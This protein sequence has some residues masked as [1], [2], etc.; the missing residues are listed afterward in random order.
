[1]EKNFLENN[2]LVLA[3][4]LYGMAFALTYNE[5]KSLQL[6]SDSF[7]IFL[8]EYSETLLKLSYKNIEERI[9]IK[10]F[11]ICFDLS[12]GLVSP[13][14]PEDGIFANFYALSSEHRAVLFLTKILGMHIDHVEEILSK[15]AY[16]ILSLEHF[17]TDKLVNSANTNENEYDCIQSKK[18]PAIVSYDGKINSK[19]FIKHMD[20]CV[21]CKKEVNRHLNKINDLNRFIPYEPLSSSQFEELNVDIKIVLKKMKGPLKINFPRPSFDALISFAKSF[22]KQIFSIPFLIC[23]A[24][25]IGLCLVLYLK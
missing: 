20:S 3:E 4:E 8:I 10:V 2:L 22:K 16:D 6:A 9:K 19:S 13:A 12:K 14:L 18:I 7:S 17:A 21:S 15:R 11:K 23:C 24:I 25:T 1:M 5:E